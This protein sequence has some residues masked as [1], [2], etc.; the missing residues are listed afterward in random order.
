M[1]LILPARDDK[2][3]TR[4]ER[5]AV[6]VCLLVFMG[7]LGAELAIDFAPAKLSVLFFLLA[8]AP[9]M[10]L[11]EAGHALVTLALGHRVERI[12]IGFGRPLWSFSLGRLKVE[13]RAIPLEGFTRMDLANKR[14][15]RLAGFS[16]YAAGPGIEALLLVIL[17]SLTGWDRMLTQTDSVVLIAVQAVCLAICVGLVTNLIPHATEN[18]RGITAN[19][20]LGM[21]LSLFPRP[22]DEPDQDP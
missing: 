9:L 4:G 20:G 18:A 5:W 17:L 12:V 2:P 3:L 10:A 13:L 7:L 1:P 19:D 22:P 21:L 15:S 14:P 8:W 11:H 6:A 16:I